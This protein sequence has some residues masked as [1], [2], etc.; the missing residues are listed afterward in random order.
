MAFKKCDRCETG[1]MIVRYDEYTC[2]LCGYVDHSF[3]SENE[4][5]R[6]DKI[7]NIMPYAL[8]QNRAGRPKAGIKSYGT[9]HTNSII[10]NMIF[11][12]ISAEAIA[13]ELGISIVRVRAVVKEYLSPEIEIGV[14]V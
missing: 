14:G 3:I 2:I 9:N 12:G 4:V 1:Q 11:D 7:K 5:I 8:A 6:L 13:N 10:I